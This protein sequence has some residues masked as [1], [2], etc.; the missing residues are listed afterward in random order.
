MRKSALRIVC[1]VALGMVALCSAVSAGTIE[2]LPS[3]MEIHR[4]S[5]KPAMAVC[6][7]KNNNGTA[8]AYNSAIEAGDRYTSFVNPENCIGSPDY[9]MSIYWISFPLY[10]FTGVQWPVGL[11]VQIYGMKTA[12]SCGGPGE[13][14]YSYHILADSSKFKAPHVGVVTLPSPVCVTGPYYVSIEYDGSTAAP[15]PSMLFDTQVPGNPCVNWAYRRSWA[16]WNVFFNAPGAGNLMVWIDGF[17]NSVFCG[18]EDSVTTT[19]EALHDQWPALGGSR[20]NVL[21]YYTGEQDGKLVSRYSDFMANTPMPPKSSLMLVGPKPDSSFIGDLVKVTGY[22]YAERDPHP[23]SPSD[24]MIIRFFPSMWSTI[25]ESAPYP[26]SENSGE[27]PSPK[28]ASPA[29]GCDSCNYGIYMGGGVNEEND[30]ARYFNELNSLGIDVCENNAF[31]LYGAGKTRTYGYVPQYRVDSLTPLNV[32]NTFIEVSKRVGNCKRHNYQPKVDLN[33]FGQGSASG[34]LT[35]SG[36][37]ISP[38][39]MRAHLQR[40]IDSGAAE[41]KITMTGSFGGDLCD[42]LKSL[43]GKGA[44]VYCQSAAGNGLSYSPETES[45]FFKMITDSTMLF[46]SY[47]RAIGDAAVGYHRYLDSMQQAWQSW[48][49]STKS[50]L[51]AHPVGSVADSIRLKVVADTA[52]LNSTRSTLLSTFSATA[53]RPRLW[54]RTQLGGSSYWHSYGAPSGGQ[55]AVN[56]AGDTSA[57]GNIVAYKDTLIGSVVVKRKV[58]VFNWNIPGTAGYSAGNSRRVMT[59]DTDRTNFWLEEDSKPFSILIERFTDQPYASSSSNPNA[60]PGFSFGG[61]DL[62]AGEFGNLPFATM[63]IPNCE[64]PGMRLDSLPQQWGGTSDITYA[65]NIA[66]LLPWHSDMELVAVVRSV[67]APGVLNIVVSGT[68]DSIVTWNITAPGVLRFDCNAQVATGSQRVNVKPSTANVSIDYFALRSK[69]LD[70]P[71]CC[72]GT[73]GNVNGLGIVDLADLSLLVGYLT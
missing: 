17:S 25:L 37:P 2:Q 57:T 8:M 44:I 35:L 10:H 63:T 29:S 55:V 71:P 65:Y 53:G 49:G 27:I 9:P 23:V 52:V 12:D 54:S 43:N 36:I 13:L 73:T 72:V 4:Y 70:P 60:F 68:Q 31:W 48:L 22:V 50:W 30:H 42:S 3:P 32:A 46:Q 18:A 67:T 47:D 6:S 20:I 64:Q 21:G 28:I 1:L 34:F 5:A 11:N 26:Q 38:A 40:L 39:T 56:F 45:R 51:I 69:A 15:Y 14:L 16:P 66:S 61:R 24:S 33:L 59:C 19:I 7:L 58:G 41:I 62:S